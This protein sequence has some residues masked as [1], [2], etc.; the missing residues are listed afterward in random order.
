[1]LFIILFHSIYSIY[2]NYSVYSNYSNYSLYI[3][4]I[5]FI[6]LT[7]FSGSLAQKTALPATNTSAP[8][9]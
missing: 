4:Y 6:N 3:H 1:M 2:S 9:S 5:P 7:A 8:A